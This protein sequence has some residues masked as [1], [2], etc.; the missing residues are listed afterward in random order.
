MRAADRFINKHFV[1]VTRSDDFL[2]ISLD[3]LLDVISRDEL[4]V[5]NEEQV[6]RYGLWK[7]GN[8]PKLIFAE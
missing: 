3:D 8:S 4:H 7:Y 2:T 5:N 6:C 1:L